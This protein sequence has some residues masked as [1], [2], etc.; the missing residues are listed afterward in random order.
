MNRTI[1][2]V[3]AVLLVFIITFAAVSICQNIAKSLRADV[4]DQRLYTL[5]KG[6]KAILAKLNQPVKVKLYYTRTAA[7]KGP[8]IIR[9]YNTYSHFVQALLEE[10]ATAAKGMIDLEIIDP[11][12]FSDEEVDAI[13]YGIRRFQISEDENFF[14]GLV[15]QTQ[16]GVEKVIDFFSPDRHNFVEYDISYLIDTAIT[17]QKTRVGVISSLAVMGDDVSGYMARMMQMQGQAPKP[18]WTII[19]QLRQKYEV[20]TVPTDVEQIKN[21]DILLVIH[22]KGFSEKTSFAID[23][24]ILKGGRAIVCIDPHCIADKPDMAQMQ[25][26]QMPSTGSNPAKLLKAWGLE[27][28]QYT[29]AGDRNLAMEYQRE[30]IIFYLSLDESKCFYSD[31]V[32][33]SDLNKVKVLFPGVLKE[34]AEKD[35]EI[36]LTPLLRTTEK[37]NSWTVSSP[38]ELVSPDHRAMIQRFVEGNEPVV[39]AYLATGKF[40][41][42]FPDGIDIQKEEDGQDPKTEHITGLT[43]A[44]Q[45]CA[46]V[47][48]ADVDFITDG[49]AYVRN[50]FG[51]T[52]ADDNSALMQNAVEDLAGSSDL[53]SIRS[54]GNFER[55]F[56]VVEAIEQQAEAETVEEEAKINAEIAGFKQELSQMLSSSTKGEEE[57][58]GQ[59][60][61]MKKKELELNIRQAQR[62]LRHIK[63]KKRQRIE[64][65]ETKLRNLCTLP[66]PVAILLIAII[67]GIKR[68]VTRRHYVSHASDA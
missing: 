34:T 43:Q 25:A 18:A 20:Q 27:M 47:V 57:I 67:L 35:P 44:N 63:S 8:D 21:V 53:I 68:S 41:S 26:G 36:K 52:V 15:V 12:P 5:S 45:D 29:F 38:Y 2:A 19:Q 22:P 4:T 7:M 9:Y 64:Q 11:R 58:I 60:I 49:M 39:M 28:P 54:R 31:S 23:Q 48:F 50:I 66:G 46:V 37:G 17:R 6:T 16:F 32:I 10:Y 33:T 65:L 51:L 13:R 56:I 62:E 40:K 59:S 3:I 55:P 24:F 30:R 1:R 61:I 42:A 14:F